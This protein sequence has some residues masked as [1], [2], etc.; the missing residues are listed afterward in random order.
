MIGDP[1]TEQIRRT[2]AEA[3]TAAM[4]DHAR[5]VQREALTIAETAEALG[6]STEWVRQQID[7]GE[8][9]AHRCGHGKAVLVPLPGLREWL[10]S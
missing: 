10:A 2:V 8:I 7:A 1:L 5:P 9:P 6:R 4:T 3:V